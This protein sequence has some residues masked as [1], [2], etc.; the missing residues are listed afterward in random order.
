[1]LRSAAAVIYST[2]IGFLVAGMFWQTFRN[3]LPSGLVIAVGGVLAIRVATL[4]ASMTSAAFLNWKAIWIG[5]GAGV[6]ALAAWWPSTGR[7]GTEP[8]AILLAPL[9]L[10]VLVVI[11]TAAT[12]TSPATTHVYHSSR[13]ARRMHHLQGVILF[14]MALPASLFW[15][16]TRPYVV[17]VTISAFGLWKLWDG[18]CPVTLTENNARAREGLPLMPPESG[19]VP[20]ALAYFGW[21]VSGKAVGLV[22]YGLGLSLCGWFGVEWF[23]K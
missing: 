20:D 7:M 15:T 18:A 17:A 4:F 10:S 9:L 12:L 5:G 1:V 23:L 16:W 3:W 2:A 11:V 13:F 14:L 21:S 19:F 22:L 8:P 6:A